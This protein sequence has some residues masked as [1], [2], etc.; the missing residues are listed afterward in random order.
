M[1]IGHS[2]RRVRALRWTSFFLLRAVPLPMSVVPRPRRSVLRRDH[3]HV[4]NSWLSLSF[5]RFFYDQQG[6]RPP[7]GLPAF[8]LAGDSL[9]FSSLRASR[10]KRPPFA[11]SFSARFRSCT[12]AATP[13]PVELLS[14]PLRQRGF[15]F[16]DRA[17]EASPKY[18]SPCG[19]T[20]SSASDFL[21]DKHLARLPLSLFSR[22]SVSGTFKPCPLNS[23]L[24]SAAS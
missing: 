13:S 24:F 14:L 5:T 15:A 1:L 6:G 7:S 23:L 18:G 9:S 2:G 16:P 12:A 20:V 3:L 19:A 21:G 22:A 10:I 8:P 17:S 11:Q 4:A